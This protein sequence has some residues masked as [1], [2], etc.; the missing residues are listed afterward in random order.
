MTEEKYR[1]SIILGCLGDALGFKN[2]RWE[3]CYS[4]SVI[5]EEF[6]SLTGEKG[7]VALDLAKF[8]LSDDSITT[9][10]NG[11]AIVEMG[12]STDYK[13]YLVKA[14]DELIK[15][16]SDMK[17]RAP[18][19]SLLYFIY[20]LR[21]LKE[22]REYNYEELQFED[23]ITTPFD[24]KSGGCGAAMRSPIIGLGFHDEDQ[25][26]RMSIEGARLSHHH[27]TGYLGSMGAALF[28]YWSVNRKYENPS[29]WIFRLLDVVEGKAKQVIKDSKR[30]VEKNLNSFGYFLEKCNNFIEKRQLQDNENCQPVYPQEWGFEQRDEFYKYLSYGG[31]GGASGHD[32]LL[33]GYDAFLWASQNGTS[34]DKESFMNL[35]RAA[36]FTGGDSDGTGLM[37]LSLWGS[38]NGWDGVE[39]LNFEKFEYYQRMNKLATNLWNRSQKLLKIKEKPQEKKEEEKEEKEEEEEE[40]EEEKQEEK[41][42]EEEKEKEKEK[43]N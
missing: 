26:I 35:I 25:V 4:G 39:K 12:E 7:L 17:W 2:N 40:K 16:V 28:N 19:R 41:E 20:Q 24:G 33:I 1:A 31:N 42:E 30:E 38:W 23:V 36:C 29:R 22:K 34:N 13:E 8:R 37:A 3:T 9:L 11:E 5:N 21:A 15:S 27:P 6:Q 18:G 14:A 32:F 10:H 43:E